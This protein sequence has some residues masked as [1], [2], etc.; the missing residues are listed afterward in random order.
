MDSTNRVSVLLKCVLSDESHRQRQSEPRT[1]ARQ[2]LIECVMGRT[3]PVNDFE[4][5]SI[6]IY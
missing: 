4:T 3:E 6:T 5:A 2:Y 1:T